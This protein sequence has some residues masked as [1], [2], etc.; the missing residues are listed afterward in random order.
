MSDLDM[1]MRYVP[2][3]LRYDYYEGKRAKTGKLAHLQQIA[4]VIVVCIYQ[5]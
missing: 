4:E 3:N 1:Q 2:A 5:T